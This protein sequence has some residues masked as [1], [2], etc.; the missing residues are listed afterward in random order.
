MTPEFTQDWTNFDKI[1]MCAYCRFKIT[2]LSCWM[3]L[4]HIFFKKPKQ[5][6]TI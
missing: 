1:K 6:M 5:F 3:T 4:L 2:V